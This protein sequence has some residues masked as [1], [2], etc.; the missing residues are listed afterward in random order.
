MREIAPELCIVHRF[1]HRFFLDA[2]IDC[3]P[4]FDA[5]PVQDGLILDDL[6]VLGDFLGP[7]PFG[8]QRTAQFERSL[9][10]HFCGHAADD[11][12]HSRTVLPD[13]DYSIPRGHGY[14][15]KMPEAFQ[16]MRISPPF[17]VTGRP[18]VAVSIHAMRG[19][20]GPSVMDL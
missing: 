18:A 2:R 14:S 19:L 9:P 16:V 8:N 4:E 11:K 7:M 6:L 3:Q 10:W 20:D 12:E 17:G 15:P 13:A 1:I 5:G